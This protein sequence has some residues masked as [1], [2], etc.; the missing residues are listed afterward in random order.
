MRK[1][2]KIINIA[3]IFMVIGVSL[4]PQVGYA[5]RVP[6]SIPGD[7]LRIKTAKENIAKK[8]ELIKL[9]NDWKN[10]GDNEGRILEL[11][12]SLLGIK[13]VS[14]FRPTRPIKP[15]ILAGGKGTR[16]K[17]TGLEGL[18]A[19]GE[20]N[21]KPSIAIV[22]DTLFSLPVTIEDPLIITKEDD[23]K[24]IKRAL[25]DY[26]VEYCTADRPLGTG[27]A[28]LQAEQVLSGFNGDVLVIYST[29][30]VIRPETVFKSIL[31]HQAMGDVPMTL[32][33]AGRNNPYAP[34]VRDSNGKIIDSVETRLEDRETVEYGEDNIGLYIVRNGDLFTVLRSAHYA[35][36]DAGKN[37]Y[38]PPGELGFPN[39][40]IRTLA[41][42]GRTVLGLAMSDPMEHQGIKEKSHLELV[43][44][45]RIRLVEKEIK[46]L[47]MRERRKAVYLMNRQLVDSDLKEAITQYSNKK[48]LITGAAGSLGSVL[49]LYLS[50]FNLKE[51][52]LLDK[53]RENLLSLEKELKKHKPSLRIKAVVM[54]IKDRDGIE[55]IFSIYKPEYVFHAAAFKYTDQLEDEKNQVEGIET[56]VIG[57]QNLIESSERNS[58]DRVVFVS[59]DKAVKPTTFYGATKKLGEMLMAAYQGSNTKFITA[60][61]VNFLGSQGSIVPVLEEQIAGEE[62]VRYQKSYGPRR[63]FIAMSEAVES[64]IN[65]GVLGQENEVYIVSFGEKIAINDL[66]ERIISFSGKDV[67]V[68]D[69]PPRPGDTLDIET[70]THDEKK[71][72]IEKYGFP[73]FKTQ[74]IGK[75][76]LLR[77]VALLKQ[78]A[79]EKDVKG[80]KEK[81]GAIVPEYVLHQG[82]IIQPNFVSTSDA[83]MGDSAAIRTKL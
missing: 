53:D 19:L 1:I 70:L 30:P 4:C 24:I 6:V 35:L 68:I 45:Y 64:I 26:Q 21:G 82:Y 38:N 77:H 23:L 15:I 34:I 63:Y 65:I 2:N 67:T 43:A 83:I 60:R 66:A 46:K 28:V 56:N 50:E 10:Y 9:V 59:S 12:C 7:E 22:L 61:C 81:L 78:L 42:Y 48:V 3:L 62:I 79:A 29:Q 17:T 71:I 58:V 8:E 25:K 36:F 74:Q 39:Q 14:D 49:S 80:L 54:D 20:V 5:L 47:A 76:E 44:S 18:K 41:R 16:A 69:I 55:R 73:A 31:V 75:D 13:S 11:S 57:T 40:M 52:V 27:Y 33:T 32:P 72:A 51:I 37:A